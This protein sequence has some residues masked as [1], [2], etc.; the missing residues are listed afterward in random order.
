MLGGVGVGGIV[1]RCGIGGG[2]GGGG[3]GRGV[4]HQLEGCRG[5]VRLYGGGGRQVAALVHAEEL[6]SGPTVVGGE[7]QVDDAG[8]GDGGARAGVGGEVD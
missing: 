3:W 6:P 2:G 5:L 1:T 4:G 7:V 8:G